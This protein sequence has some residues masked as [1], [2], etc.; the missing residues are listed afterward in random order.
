MQAVLAARIDRLPPEEKNLLQTAAV[1]GKDVPA[2]L[3]QATAD[4]PLGGLC[5]AAWRTCRP[6]SSSMRHRLFP[7]PAYTFK[8]A[9]TQ[10]V[11]YNAVLLERRRVLA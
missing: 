9:L 7:E 1:I 2:A 8:H 6:R 3:L 10:E 4:S 5:S 11:A